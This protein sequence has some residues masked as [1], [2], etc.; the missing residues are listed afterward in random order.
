M[1]TAEATLQTALVTANPLSMINMAISQ[2]RSPEELGKLLDLQERWERN[3]A[4]KEFAAAMNTC[5]SEMETVVKNRVNDHTKSGYADL[6]A[7][8]T[9]IKPIYTRCGFAPMFSESPSDKDGQIRVSCKL[10]HIG[11]HSESF[12]TDV[13]LDGV[14]VKGSAM[15]TQLQGKG[16]SLTYGRR[17]LLAMIFN[18][19]TGDDKDG[20]TSSPKINGEEVASLNNMIAACRDAGKPIDFERFLRAAGVPIGGN[21]GDITRDKFVNAMNLLTRKISAK[22]SEPVSVLK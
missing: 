8:N 2:G 11:G 7:V 15:M 18:I 12:Y 4:V 16:S 21:L 3:N 22:A 9:A 10:Q 17:Y 5:Q 13:F 6:A 19:S 1:T 20:N 14:G